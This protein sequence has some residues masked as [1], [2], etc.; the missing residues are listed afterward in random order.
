MSPEPQDWRGL[1]V[2]WFNLPFVAGF[3]WG[4][5]SKRSWNNSSDST[6]TADQQK[7]HIF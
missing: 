6:F 4:D 5:G 7:Q 3:G 1:N 2:M